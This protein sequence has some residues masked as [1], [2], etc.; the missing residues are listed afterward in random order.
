MNSGW[1]GVEGVAL[2]DTNARIGRSPGDPNS[3]DPNGLIKQPYTQKEY[4]GGFLVITVEPKNGG[5]PAISFNFY[6]E[7]G[8]A[9]YTCRKTA[10]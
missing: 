8:E 6:D 5:N 4:S 1:T 9:L 3:T 2:V 10:K 7:K